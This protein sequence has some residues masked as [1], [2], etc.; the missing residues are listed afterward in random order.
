MSLWE[1]A[2]PGMAIASA[3]AAFRGRKRHVADPAGSED[4]PV[5]ALAAHGVTAKDTLLS[6][7]NTLLAALVSG[8][9]NFGVTDSF[10]VLAARA[11]GVPVVAVCGLYKGVPGLALVV[12]PSLMQSLGLQPGAV[13]ADLGS[14]RARPSA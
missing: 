2:P 8:G 4:L 14:S 7:S 13:A 10:A 11:K 9:V 3:V 6:S 1:G 12:R 5:Q